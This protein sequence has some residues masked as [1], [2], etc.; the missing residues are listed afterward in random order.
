MSIE[1]LRLMTDRLVLAPVGPGE[2]EHHIA[3]M[4]DPRVA[5]FLTL[6]KQP[7]KRAD[8]WRSYA[9]L[10]GHWRMRGF[11]FFSVF[12]RASGA[13]VGRVGPWQPDGWPGIECGWGIAPAHWGQGY[14]PEAAVAAIRWLF[15]ARPDL[16]RIISLIAPENANSQ[17]VARKIG[18]A[19]TNET[20][21]L[22]SIVLDVWAAP[23]EAWL[24][25]HA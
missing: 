5:R 7:Q 1:A 24:A 25:R 17:A 21:Q 22:E 16:P 19:K 13:W 10:L 9:T 6:D 11:G 4:A 23:R 15:S 12:E 8:A 2:V 20:F 3:M 14:A 18:E